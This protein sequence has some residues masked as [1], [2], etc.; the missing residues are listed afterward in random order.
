MISIELLTNLLINFYFS[1]YLFV[2]GTF[3]GIFRIV[4]RLITND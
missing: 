4:R 1:K 2:A 3:Y